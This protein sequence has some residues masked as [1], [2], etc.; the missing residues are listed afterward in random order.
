METKSREITLVVDEKITN[1]VLLDSLRE[2]FNVGEEWS[3]DKIKKI[4][5]SPEYDDV[6]LFTKQEERKLKRILKKYGGYLVVHHYINCDEIEIELP[7]EANLSDNE[8]FYIEDL[9]YSIDSFKPGSINKDWLKRI[10]KFE[11]EYIGDDVGNDNVNS[12]NV[13]PYTKLL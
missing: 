9:E 4:I 1:R 13:G 10:T 12:L 2:V 11:D 5:L 8:E 6:T 7:E 3:D